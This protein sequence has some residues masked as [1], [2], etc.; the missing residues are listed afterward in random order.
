MNTNYLDILLAFIRVHS[1]FKMGLQYERQTETI[2]QN[3]IRS[4]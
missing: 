3:E 2:I 4:R 1:R